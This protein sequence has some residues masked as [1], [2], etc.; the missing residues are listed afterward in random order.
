ML[1]ALDQEDFR[2]HYFCATFKYKDCFT[3]TSALQGIKP[4]FKPPIQNPISFPNTSAPNGTSHT[5]QAR[6]PRPIPV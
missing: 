5:E 1:R 6:V 2:N 4:Y 3:A